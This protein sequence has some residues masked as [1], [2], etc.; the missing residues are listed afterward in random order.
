MSHVTIDD[1]ARMVKN[2]FD[3]QREEMNKRFDAV[4]RRFDQN[5][6]AHV[7]IRSDIASIHDD[8]S[9][10]WK[11]LKAINSKLNDLLHRP[12]GILLKSF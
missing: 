9:L 11:E 3:E 1:L 7:A 4:D 10:I 5:E 12:H 6:A 2:G 8:I